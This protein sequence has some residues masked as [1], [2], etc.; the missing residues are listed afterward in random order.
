[1]T[2]STRATRA[3]AQAV[4]AAALAQAVC[5]TTTATHTRRA[6]LAI[7]NAGRP[8]NTHVTYGTLARALKLGVP[9]Q[10]GRHNKLP[11]ACEAEL[12]AAISEFQR[13]G[14]YITKGHLVEAVSEIIKDLPVEQQAQWKDGRP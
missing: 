2:P 10:P 11:A 14:F 3:S 12:A 4:R 5:L 1:M 13:N 7:V 9:T 8:A 6:A